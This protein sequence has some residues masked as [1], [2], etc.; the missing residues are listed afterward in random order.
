MK[1]QRQKTCIDCIFNDEDG[2]RDCFNVMCRD[3]SGCDKHTAG[4]KRIYYF[5]ADSHVKRVIRL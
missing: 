2:V 3:C 5:D 1:K 4:L